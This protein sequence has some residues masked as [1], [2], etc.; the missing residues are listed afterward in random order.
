M[1]L[2]FL[3]NIAPNFSFLTLKW[4][5]LARFWCFGS[6]ESSGADEFVWLER[7]GCHKTSAEL[8]LLIWCASYAA[9]ALS[10]ICLSSKAGQRWTPFP[11][12]CM[13]FS[14]NH[15]FNSNIENAFCGCGLDRMC[16][17]SF[18]SRLSSEAPSHLGSL[19][20]DLRENRREFQ[21]CRCTKSACSVSSAEL[22]RSWRSL[23]L[24]FQWIV[25]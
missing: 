19:A 21:M 1:G 3:K 8:R 9:A 22:N 20:N 6:K 23:L 13:C 11:L 7:W 18:G 17:E 15:R 4:V 25:F 14:T 5:R 10:I 16:L 2:L 24:L 12:C